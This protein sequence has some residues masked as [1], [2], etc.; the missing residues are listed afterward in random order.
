MSKK[1]RGYSR[2][3]FLFLLIIILLVSAYYGVRSLLVSWNIFQIEKIEIS[4]YENLEKD[5]LLYFARDFLG[6]NLFSISQQDVLNKY[7][8]IVRVKSVEMSRH[9]PNVLKL[10]FQERKGIFQV[11]TAEG[12][13]FPIDEEKIV[14]DN[15]NFYNSEVLPV[16][17]T[18]IKTAEIKIGEVVDDFFVDRI[19][20]LYEKI[21]AADKNFIDK[22]SEFY[23]D[24]NQIVLV[25]SSKGYKII[26][27]EENIASKLKRFSFLEQH[28]T[29]EAGIVVDLQ[30]PNSLIIRTEDE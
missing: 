29:F 21:L 9:I 28:R 2:Y 20:E 3:F 12:N 26:L 13:L 16:I 30:F 25:E 18:N 11:K 14:L 15:D 24:D 27:G 22:I 8:N 5:F 6:K 1:R 19:L 17:D 7:D 4:G 23:L 10:K